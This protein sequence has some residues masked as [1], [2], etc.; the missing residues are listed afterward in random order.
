MFFFCANWVFLSLGCPFLIV[1]QPAPGLI[2]CSIYITRETKWVYLR[3]TNELL[4]KSRSQESRK[5]IP[6][7]NGKIWI[8]MCERGPGRMNTPEILISIKLQKHKQSLLTFPPTSLGTNVLTASF[9][10]FALAPRH[11]LITCGHEVSNNWKGEMGRFCFNKGS[12]ST[13]NVPQQY[14]SMQK[15]TVNRTTFCKTSF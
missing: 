9:H 8:R 6:V 4:P 15:K 12:L 13:L 7:A 3:S 11:L 2:R 14:L 10:F 5:W 1:V